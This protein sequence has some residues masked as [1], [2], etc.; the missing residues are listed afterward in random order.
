MSRFFIRMAGPAGLRVALLLC[1]LPAVSAQE[2]SANDTLG[3]VS[4]NRDVRPLIAD[5]CFHCHGPDANDRKGKLRLDQAGGPQGAYR[6]LYGTQAI[7]PGSLDDSELWYRLTTDD[8]NDAMPPLES[9]KQPLD[10]SERDLIKRWIEQGA[11]YEDYWAFVAPVRPPAAKVQ[12]DQW[13][14]Q[15]LD[16]F[17]LRALET[18]GLHPSPAAD[19]RTLIRRVSFDLTGLPPTRDEIQAFLSDTSPDA[20]EHVVDRLLAS[21]R[22]GEHMAKYW[23]D[24][25]RF[26]DSNGIHHD[27]YREMSPYRDWVIRAWNANLPYDE[28]IAYQLAGDLYPEPTDDQLIA[29]GF[30]R[31]HMIIDV[32]TALPEES[33][34]RNVIDR[35]TAVGT[36]FLGITVQCAVCHDHKYDPFTQRDFYQLSAFFNN[37]DAKPETGSGASDKKRGLQPPYISFPTEEQDAALQ[38]VLQKL[39]A[40]QVEVEE[41][42]EGSEEALKVLKAERDNILFTI[43][44]AMVMKERAEIRSAHIQIR[45]AYDSPGEVVERGTPSFLPPLGAEGEFKTRMDLARWLVAREHPL[46]ARVTVNRVW[47]QFFGVGIVKTSEDFGTQGAWP[48]HIDLLDEL[49]VSFVE[50]GWD[51]KALVKQ[52]VMSTTYRQSSADD[53]AD[54]ASDPENRQLARGSRFRMDAEMIR[55]QILATSGLLNPA[56]YGKSVKPPQPDGVW[57]AVTLPSSFPR[58]YEADTGDK[59]VRRSVYTYWKRGMPPPQMSMLNAPT[60]ES[61]VARRERTNTPLQALLLLNEREYLKAARHLAAATL[62]GDDRSDAGRLR[63][64]YE[65]ITS[66]LP[67]AGESA[68]L[69]RAVGDLRTMYENNTVLAEQ[70]C[71]GLLLDESVTPAQL[72][73]W[74]VLTSTV[75]NL[76]VTKT[77]E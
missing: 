41:A 28:F 48:S 12:N 52:L 70:L 56:M 75:Y 68:A 27:H 74:T 7:T 11:A 1:A 63:V 2:S 39:T 26:A 69:L 34:S 60:R 22:H 30:N 6:T 19:D 61:C 14:R 58:T 54:F 55:D 71:E 21:P 67:D 36:A 44:A 20:Y 18:S 62:A 64:I 45:G 9:H 46:T 43:P 16:R 17:V 38:A 72:A 59:T 33:F 49:S 42:I 25:V 65:T 24:L 35:V 8:E 23:L 31:L 40:A 13:C 73:A 66:K 29:S 51:V 50:S 32:G 4:F 10:A 77:R 53:P 57:K 47:Q 37:L 5:R 15:P 76:D 3:T